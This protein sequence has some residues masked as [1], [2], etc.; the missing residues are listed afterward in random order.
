MVAG[1]WDRALELG[2][3]GRF[4]YSTQLNQCLYIF[5]SEAVDI[6]VWQYCK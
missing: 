1:Q 5:G 3:V 4:C 2:N 6:C